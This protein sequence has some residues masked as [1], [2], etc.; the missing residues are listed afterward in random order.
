MKSKVTDFLSLKPPKPVVR[1][2]QPGS[3]RRDAGIQQ[4]MLEQP[5]AESFNAWKQQPTPETSDALLKTLQPVM[6]SALRT[7]AGSA[8]TSPTMR[9]K[10]KLILLKSLNT[11]DPKQSK[12]RTF[13]MT[14]LQGL[15]RSA[16][17]ESQII[18]VPELVRLDQHR[19][20]NVEL[21]LADKLGRPPSSA[22]VAAA[23]GVS[24]KRLEH[25]RKAKGATAV[26]TIV[27]HDATD[28]EDMDPTIMAAPAA[29]RRN[30]YL[31]FIYQDLDPRDQVIME[32]TLGLHGKPVLSK[33][34]IAAKLGLSAGAVSQRA[35]RIQAIIDRHEDNPLL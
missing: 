31:N 5:F 25:V 3:I 11:Y 6:D 15:R 35:A 20:H 13:A 9:S 27:K 29:R 18:G 8:A 1:P 4:N 34:Q 30:V 16:A 12:L 24:L 19:I 22:E 28:E 14:N 32:S 21:E 7:F 2:A 17:E 33:G 26:G 23:A 10:A